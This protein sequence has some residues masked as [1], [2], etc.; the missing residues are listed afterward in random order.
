[1][2]KKLDVVLGSI[3]NLAKQNTKHKVVKD[4]ASACRSALNEPS[5][6]NFDQLIQAMQEMKKQSGKEMSDLFGSA[7]GTFGGV[8]EALIDGL[9]DKST[10]FQ[11]YWR[12]NE[13][14]E[15]IEGFINEEAE[16]RRLVT[17]VCGDI[18]AKLKIDL[19]EELDP[20]PPTPISPLV[21]DLDGD[22][23]ET[24]HL[25]VGITFDHN[26]N[27][28]LQHT[29]FVAADD[30]F[31]ALDLNG[32][33]SIDSGR[34]LFGSNTQ[35][36]DGTLADNGFDAL[37]QYDDNSDGVI[38]SQDAIYNQLKIFRDINQDGV[39]Q[40]EELFGLGDY[41][42]SSLNL[43]YTLSDY[44]DE[45]GNEHR[46]VS[47][48]TDSSGASHELTDVWF[49]VGREIPDDPDLDIPDDIL[50]LP[51]INGIGS[52]PSLR[53]AM[54]L[55]ET[56]ELKALVEEYVQ[57]S[58]SRVP[59]DILDEIIFAWANV[60]DSH[61]SRYAGLNMDP[62]RI[63][64]LEA[65]YGYQIHIPRLAGDNFGSVFNPIYEKV[66]H[67]ITLRMTGVE[68]ELMDQ[69]LWVKDPESGNLY[70][71]FE[72]VSKKLIELAMHDD[73]LAFN[74]I[75]HFFDKIKLLDDEYAT[76]V[77]NLYSHLF[78][79]VEEFE[80]YDFNLL[81]KVIKLSSASN[82]ISGS[83]SSDSIHGTVTSD[84]ITGLLG[85]DHI[86]AGIGGD[87]VYGD[88][89]NDIIEGGEGGGNDKLYGGSGNDVILASG[90][91]NHYLSGGS[92][93]DVI[94]LYGAL[95]NF[96]SNYSITYEGGEGDDQIHGGFSKD[97]YIFD[98]GDGNDTIFNLGRNDKVR[99]GEGLNREN[100]RVYF[101]GNDVVLRFVDSSGEFSGDSIT[102]NNELRN[103]DYAIEV[104][105]F[106]DGSHLTHQ[107][108]RKMALT[109]DG[110]DGDDV[111]TGSRYADTISSGDGDDIVNAGEGDDIVNGGQG[112]DVI[113]SS[114]GSAY[115]NG[116]QGNDVI[117][118]SGGSAYLNG[119]QGNDTLTGHSLGNNYLSGGEGDDVLKLDGDA[120]P[121]SELNVVNTFEGGAGDDL[122]FGGGGTSIYRFS[123]GDGRDVINDNGTGSTSVDRIEFTG[124]E[125]THLRVSFSGS[126]IVLGFVDE[127]GQLTR[128]AITI[129]Q[130]FDDSS[131]G[132]EEFHFADNRVLTHQDVHALARVIYGSDGGE[133][134]NGSDYSDTIM[135]GDGDDTVMAGNGDDLLYGDMGNDTLIAGKSSSNQMFGGEGDD[136]LKLGDDAFTHIQRQQVN[137]FEGGLGNDTIIGGCSQDI[138]IFNQGDGHDTIEDPDTYAGQLDRIEFGAG[139]KVENLSVSFSEN[140]ILLEFKD[141]SGLVTQDAI[142]IKNAFLTDNAIEQLVFSDGTIL[143]H[144]EVH[145]LARTIE[146]TDGNDELNGSTLSD[147]IY[148]GTGDDTLYGNGAKDE[149]DVIY[150]GEGN[151]VLIGGH[152]GNS[153]LYGGAGD[154]IL[155]LDGNGQYGYTRTFE[156]GEG[157]DILMGSASAEVYVIGQGDGHDTITDRSPYHGQ[158]DKVIF[159][160]GL[161]RDNLRAGVLGDALEL[162][163]VDE[164]GARTG[165][166]VTVNNALGNSQYGIEEYI[167]A[168]GQ[169]LTHEELRTE[170]LTLYGTDHHDEI[171]GTTHSDTIY[172]KDGHDTIVADYGHDIVY[173]GEGHDTIKAGHGY[174]TVYA[175]EGND[176]IDAGRG[177][178]I[179]YGGEGHDEIVSLDGRNKLYGENGNDR[180]TAYGSELYG[181]ADGD[182]LTSSPN[183]SEGNRLVG[184]TGN[185]TLN[186]NHGSDIYV[187]NRG[188]GRD[189][190]H[191]LVDSTPLIQDRIEFGADISPDDVRIERQR[192]NLAVIIG[193]RW[194]GDCITVWDYFIGEHKQVELVQFADGSTMSLEDIPIYTDQ[195]P[196]PQTASLIQAMS[197]FESTDAVAM[198]LPDNNANSHLL[199][200]ALVKSELNL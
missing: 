54:L 36:A 11:D 73:P 60:P 75:Y 49:Q 152:L 24:T 110:A 111:I 133:T 81:D 155:K 47:S 103:T 90:V 168:D 23:I 169:I 166:G 136:V 171:K 13:H 28:L 120:A 65:F 85:D 57:V 52:L 138:Y 25:D 164:S 89:G 87:V 72:A 191:E 43:N 6:K 179:V 92:G 175:G 66:K 159:K 70:G 119:D 22:G 162:Y 114:G 15:S 174:D 194:S 115:L 4:L 116:D 143:T 135:A 93:D 113:T 63:M 88:G 16:K 178:D 17:Q 48:Y 165:D 160:Q 132:I 91:G 142:T 69:V 95:K 122:L 61:T 195:T 173:A 58:S 40:E 41:H 161:K 134:L 125:S 53:Q 51:D 9:L 154:D 106:A 131:F 30:G 18:G 176:R 78:T 84:F 96:G 140:D 38:D 192:D 74:K 167:F 79:S 197:A 64:A 188:D 137:R 156:G 186:G 196:P 26:A 190:I 3:D 71:D 62:K 177:M 109:I 35:L 163:F 10:P 83:Y 19:L 139:L 145:A 182:I 21:L 184:G 199:Q 193:S 121:S 151:D 150:G 108:V 101:S 104:F 14:R 27:G 50:L 198:A 141:D 46:Q 153:N 45:N 86:Y 99:F 39:S 129:E 183:Y 112:N 80:G 55:D 76:N 8:A 130:A 172:G 34:E 144:E 2:T 170:A 56:G 97:V 123:R 107:E 29:G 20:A 157:Q 126:D 128:D 102:L 68:S 180:I 181:G 59:G 185:D 117:T 77:T 94:K 158:D 189:I 149:A 67:E 82:I 33:G 98:K 148:G 31:L 118:S 5:D 37:R 7:G 146:G 187:F 42:I 105:L 200:P 32:N 124:I 12:A 127:L 44:I 1:M 100:L 147:T